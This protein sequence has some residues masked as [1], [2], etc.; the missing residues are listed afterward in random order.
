MKIAIS[1]SAILLTSLLYAESVDEALEG[2]DDTPAAT[3]ATTSE[4]SSDNV[5]EGFD[6]DVTEP[7]PVS[8]E[9]ANDVEMDGFDDANVE[10]NGTAPIVNDES[11]EGGFF[12]YFSG[13]LT[14][15]MAMGYNRNAAQNIFAS[16]RQTLFLDYDRKFENGL[17]VKVN[18]RAFYDPMYDMSNADYYPSEVDELRTEIWLFEAYLE[19]N[20]MQNFDAKL[21]RQVVVWGRSDSIRIT[22][23]LNPL[24]FRRPG[25]LDIEN[26][27]LPTTMLKLDYQIDNWRISPIAIVEQRFSKYPAFGSIYFPDERLPIQYS[28]YEESGLGLPYVS[29]QSYK[30]ITFALSAEADF[31]GWDLSLYAARVRQDQGFIDKNQQNAL[32]V[33]IAS[34]KDYNVK[35]QHNKTNMF[36]T[37]VSYVTGSWL[38]KTELAY[39]SDLVYSSISDRTLSRTDGLLGLEYT[40]FA[41][42]TLSYDF[43][44]RHFNQY[45]DRLY[46]PFENFLERDS[47]QQAFRINSNFVNDTLHLNYLASVFGKKLNEG[48]F[49]RAWIDYEVADAI[50]ATVGIVDYF[51]GSNDL[52]KTTLFDRVDK[53]NIVYM[54]MSYSF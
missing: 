49:Q 7:T 11:R 36:G 25:T 50:N 1:L 23:I 24:D 41:N 27:R 48:G 19:W 8:T 39:F 53:F 51:G 31:E 5:M 40:G 47:Y 37:A 18:G 52:G 29:D 13:K 33:S 6:D 26:L 38:L 34:G 22:D 2:F 46:V 21:G 32:E 43:S 14:Q 17:K 35:I 54:D 44:L 9:T 20:I 10:N 30:D 42:T 45:D 16:L 4:S 15:Q 12:S 28:D 3:S